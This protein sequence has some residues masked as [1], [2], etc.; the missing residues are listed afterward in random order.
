MT[1]PCRQKEYQNFIN[2]R[3]IFRY[4]FK[5]R[6]LMFGLQTTEILLILT[7][8]SYYTKIQLHWKLQIFGGILNWGFKKSSFNRTRSFIIMLSRNKNNSITEITFF[9]RLLIDL[10]TNKM[11]SRL[12][13][14]F[15]L[16]I[17]LLIK[18]RTCAGVLSFKINCSFINNIPFY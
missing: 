14:S 17:V 7:Q 5:I 15:S 9:L 18:Q 1:C 2:N 12:T 3:Y 16:R 13:A 11:F 10:L 8:A 6:S 4:L